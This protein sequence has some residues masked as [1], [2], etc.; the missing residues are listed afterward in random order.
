MA[1]S[2]AKPVAGLHWKTRLLIGVVGK[3]MF[4]QNKK[5]EPN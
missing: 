1:C 5:Q 4:Q 2:E 3:G